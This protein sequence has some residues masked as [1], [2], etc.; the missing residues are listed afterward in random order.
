MGYETFFTLQILDVTENEEVDILHDLAE[1]IPESAEF[2]SYWIKYYDYHE[3][4]MK[5]ST[6]YPNAIFELL[7][8]G[9][10]RFY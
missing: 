10:E 1:T 5:F 7:G 6:K 9:L 2:G 3:D 4:F 8:E